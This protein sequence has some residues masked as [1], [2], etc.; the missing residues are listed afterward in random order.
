ME[1]VYAAMLLHKAGNTINEANVKKVADAAGLKADDAQIKAL[2]AALN[3][4]DIDKA[5][6]EAAMPVA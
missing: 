4:V 5:I 3:G 6:K 2:C 1:L